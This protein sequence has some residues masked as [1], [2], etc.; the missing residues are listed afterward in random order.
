M[1]TILSVFIILHG[2]VHIWYILIINRIV[3]FTPNMGWTGKSWLFSQCF[4]ENSLRYMAI[5][6]YLLVTLLFM[7]SGLAILINIEWQKT[8]ITV[9]ALL[10]SLTIIIFFDGKFELLVQKGFLGLI[11]NLIIISII[12]YSR[13]KLN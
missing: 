1:K 2:L 3:D 11:I 4:S 12:L 9:A 13:I 7:I 6:L 5:I 8:I 10:S